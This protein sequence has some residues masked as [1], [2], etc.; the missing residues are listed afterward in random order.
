MPRAPKVN[1]TASEPLRSQAR[2][3]VDLYKMAEASPD[4]RY[5]VNPD[6]APDERDYLDFNDPRLLLSALECFAEHGHFNDPF[7]RS[8][9]Q[10]VV[11]GDFDVLRSQGMTYE[12]SV[13]AL[14]TKHARS[15]SA[16]ERLVKQPQT[17][18]KAD[19]D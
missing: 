12:R 6:D 18:T 1:R 3:L 8:V 4:H 13:E 5:C 19:G 2:A 9:F 16:I 14:S 7:A 10:L 17:V 15:T 11:R